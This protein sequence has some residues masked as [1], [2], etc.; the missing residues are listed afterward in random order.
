MIGKIEEATAARRQSRRGSAQYDQTPSL[1]PHAD[2]KARAV[3]LLCQL[4]LSTPSEDVI[5]CAT[6]VQKPTGPAQEIL[7]TDF[8]AFTA[9]DQ[10]THQQQQ[11]QPH[12]DAITEVSPP[13]PCKKLDRRMGGGRK[14]IC[15][16]DSIIDAFMSTK[17]DQVSSLAVALFEAVCS[18]ERT[19]IADSV[20]LCTGAAPPPP[21][22][23]E[24][25][26]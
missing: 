14:R 16:G 26:A 10:Y 18:P 7:T 15:L 23:S 11:Q 17:T 21:W 13:S 19:T 22:Q 25:G 12:G 5:A 6:A 20:S 9:G 24:G 8:S 1:S 2:L 4:Y 3:L